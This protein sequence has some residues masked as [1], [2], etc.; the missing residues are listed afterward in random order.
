M[1][2]ERMAETDQE[3]VDEL[4]DVEDGLTEWEIEF[5]DSLAKHL[6]TPGNTLSLKRRATLERIVLRCRK[7]GA[8]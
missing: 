5:A 7:R 8:P 6:D 2:G 1:V 3:L 4:C